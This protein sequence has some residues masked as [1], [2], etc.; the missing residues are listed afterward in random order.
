MTTLDP[1]PKVIVPFAWM[2]AA[3]HDLFARQWYS[4]L[5]LVTLKMYMDAQ[6]SAARAYFP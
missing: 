3:A 6:S 1:R 5:F 2:C 4:W